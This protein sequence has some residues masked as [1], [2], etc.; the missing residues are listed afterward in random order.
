MIQIQLLTGFEKT[1]N[2]KKKGNVVK[3]HRNYDQAY[4]D[5]KLPCKLG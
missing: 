1:N 2:S 3:E 5:D 4:I